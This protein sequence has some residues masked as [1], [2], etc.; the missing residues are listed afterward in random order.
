MTS[1]ILA[2]LTLGFLSLAGNAQQGGK[3]KESNAHIGL[4]YPLSTNGISALDYKNRFSIHAIGGASASEEG[5]CASGFGNF[6]RYNGNGVVASGFSNIILENGEG[7]HLAGF[8][9][10][11]KNNSKGTAIRLLRFIVWF[12]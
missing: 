9:N 5:F 4:V 10:M 8:I 12:L 7:V 1:K 6:I 11:I 2:T 3:I